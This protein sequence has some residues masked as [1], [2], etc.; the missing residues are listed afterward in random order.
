MAVLI[1]ISEIQFTKPINT[2]HILKLRGA[3]CLKMQKIVLL[4]NL[5]RMYGHLHC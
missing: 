3:R 2:Q 4:L 5:V 1:F